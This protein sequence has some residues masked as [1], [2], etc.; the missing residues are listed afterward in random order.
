VRG[1]V[2]AIE[3]QIDCWGCPFFFQL[4]DAGNADVDK[5][6]FTGQGDHHS[7]ERLFSF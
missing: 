7:M 4:F 3:S 1:A 2:G 6:E 5:R